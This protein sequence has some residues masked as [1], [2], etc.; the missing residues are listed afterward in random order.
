[1]RL[2]WAIIPRAGSS[3]RSAAVR[4]LRRSCAAVLLAAVVGVAGACSSGSNT[5]T[6]PAT[7]ALS[8]IKT[9]ADLASQLEGKGI[10]C[11]L[12]YEGLR[13]EDKTL[14]ICVIS[15]EQATLTIWDKPDVL[16][17]FVATPAT[18]V[19]A[20]AVGQNWSVDVDSAPVAQKVATALGGQV[21]ASS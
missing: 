20:T 11:K 5:G 13:Q 6:S 10:E 19:G 3:L 16:A 15:G 17:K 8:N 2:T 12:E 14:S 4:P 18:G 21:K 1:M 9:I 7:T